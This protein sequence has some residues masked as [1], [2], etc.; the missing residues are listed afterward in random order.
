M[1]NTLLVILLAASQ[2]FA[3]TVVFY[4]DPNAF[5][6]AIGAS[7]TIDFEGVVPDNGQHD[8]FASTGSTFSPVT[9]T[10]DLGP[11]S[12]GQVDEVV[13][14]KNAA[15]A[16]SNFASAILSEGNRNT[17]IANLPG[18]I[19]AVGSFVG[20]VYTPNASTVNNALV[21]TLTGAG[22]NLD[23]RI[24]PLSGFVGSTP[25]TG[26]VGYVVSGDTIQSLKFSQNPANFPTA[27]LGIDN[28]Q[29]GSG[30]PEPGTYG[31][32]ALGLM[33]ASRLKI[34]KRLL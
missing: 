34:R 6:A 19:T 32:V 23:T 11:A 22:G 21:L 3:A 8:Y 4:N 33:L 16:G 12:A 26:F 31:L 1:K 10:G 7:N 9:F 29:F 13:V 5:A 30:V 20:E 2:S 28:L 15:Y 18:G 25:P 14:G 17:I 24:V 27:F